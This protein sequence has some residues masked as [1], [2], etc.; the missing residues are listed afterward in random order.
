[1]SDALTDLA[2]DNMRG[3]KLYKYFLKLIEYLKVPEE[4]KRLE[5][6]NASD[7]VD[8]ISGGYFISRT[9]IKERLEKQLNNL[10][11]GNKEEWAKVLRQIRYGSEMY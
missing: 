6:I 7:E 3:E 8:S 10:Q 2:K 5:L 4:E 1:M 11:E 9:R